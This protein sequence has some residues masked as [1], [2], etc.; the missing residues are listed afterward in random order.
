MATI[1]ELSQL[2]QDPLRSILDSLDAE[3]KK[4]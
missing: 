2:G 4:E 1:L 3:E